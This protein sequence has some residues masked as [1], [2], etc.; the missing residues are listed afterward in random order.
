[1]ALLQAVCNDIQVGRLDA[2]ISFVLTN[3]GPGEAAQSD[4][5]QEYAHSQGLPVVS[6]SSRDFRQKYQ[7]A[8][9]RTSFDQRMSSHIEQY[10]VDLIFLAGYM[11]IV[12]DL[13]CTR[14]L[15]LNLH[16]ALPGGPTGTWQEVMAELA[17]TGA[18]KAGAMVH[19]VTPELDR[20]PTASYFSFSLEGEPF[21]TL[22]QAGEVDAL[23]DAI[24]AEEVR[25]EFPLILT[26]LRAF[27][28]GDIR[29]KDRC[30]YDSEGNLMTAGRDLSAEVERQLSRA[31]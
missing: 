28:A 18:A 4:L 25:R 27:A 23:A 14:Y 1:L 29:V 8:D 11:L 22:R 10:D 17:R 24:R 19:V 13:F 3:R 2:H 30:A 6:E 16:P 21:S 7:G 20:G 31:P 12:S 15:L 9:W 26:T 5:F